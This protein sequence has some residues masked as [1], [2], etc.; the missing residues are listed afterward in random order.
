MVT[1]SQLI[2]VTTFFHYHCIFSLPSASTSAICSSLSDR[3]TQNFIP[4]EYGPLSASPTLGCQLSTDFNHRT[5]ECYIP[6]TLLPYYPHYIVSTLFPLDSQAQSTNSLSLPIDLQSGQKEAV[7]TLNSM[8]SLLYP[9]MDEFFSLELKLLGS[10]ET[11]VAGAGS[12]NFASGSLGIIVCGATLISQF[13]D[14]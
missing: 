6:N 4:E 13:L 2:F 9:Q 8:E 7:S 5:R 12:K 1:W 14:P 3:V 10:A 11:K